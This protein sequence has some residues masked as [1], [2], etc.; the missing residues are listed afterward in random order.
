[1]RLQRKRFISR[2]FKRPRYD[3]PRVWAR[4]TEE[5]ASLTSI[6]GL[7]NNIV[8]M[9]SKTLEA[10]SVSIWL[11]DEREEVLSLGGSTALASGKGGPPPG[12]AEKGPRG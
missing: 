12:L 4:F 8:R 3:Y 11:W 1:L 2:H 9:V 10:L 6:S 5:T 7:C